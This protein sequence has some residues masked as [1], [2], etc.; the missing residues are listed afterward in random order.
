MPVMPALKRLRQGDREFRGL[1]AYSVVQHLPSWNKILSSNSI[2]IHTQF[3]ASLGY[4]V[5]SRG[6]QLSGRAFD[7]IVRAR[8]SCQA[9][10]VHACDPSTQRQRPSGLSVQGQLGLQ[11]EFQDSQPE[12]HR[13]TLSL[14]KKKKKQELSPILPFH[15][16]IPWQY[17]KEKKKS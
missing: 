5:R 12:L 3:Q 1:D 8:I 10:V 6:V 16:K 17:F 13:E 2:T 15:Y 7:C 14:R 4:I 9:V 11:S